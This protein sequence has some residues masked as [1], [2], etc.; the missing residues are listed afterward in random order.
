MAQL[1]AHEIVWSKVAVILS[2]S[3]TNVARTFIISL[4]SHFGS[5]WTSGILNNP[6][7]PCVRVRAPARALCT[8]Q[9]SASFRKLCHVLTGGPCSCKKQWPLESLSGESVM[10]EKSQ[11]L[12]I[13]WL[14]E[15][16]SLLLKLYHLPLPPLCRVPT[17]S[18]QPPK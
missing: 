11:L 17:P 1:L 13:C 10:P 8:G 4:G 7:G 3:N 9:C 5:V 15:R 12:T 16:L 18:L 6:S 14:L 2:I